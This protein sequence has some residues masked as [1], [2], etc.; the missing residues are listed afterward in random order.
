MATIEHTHTHTRAEG[1][2]FAIL[3]FGSE[4]CES[5]MFAFLSGYKLAVA[6]RTGAPQRELKTGPT[7][8]RKP[9]SRAA[10]LDSRDSAPIGELLRK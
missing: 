3:Q 9:D 8:C 7:N 5:D 1:D 4:N 6:S 10:D 2:I